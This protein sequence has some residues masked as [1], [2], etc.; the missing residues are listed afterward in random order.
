MKNE[1]L[2]SIEDMDEAMSRTADRCDIWQDRIVYAVCR[3]VRLLLI[4][5]VRR[6]E[7]EERENGR[8]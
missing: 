2:R 3:A 8:N 5:E 4:R 6:I 1:L 7:K